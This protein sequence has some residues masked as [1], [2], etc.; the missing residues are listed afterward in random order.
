MKGKRFVGTAASAALVLLLMAGLALAQ[1][2]ASTPL[3]TGFTYQ[4]QLKS[5]DAPYSGTCDFNFALWDALTGGTQIGSTLPKTNVSLSGG[6]FTLALDFGTGRFQ[7]DGRWLAIEVRCPAGSGTYTLLT[8]RQAL[9]AAPYALA[10]PGL[11]TQPNASSP[12]LVGGYNGNWLTSG[13]YAATI[14]GGGFSGSPNRVTDNSGTVGGGYSNQAGDSAGTVADAAKATVGGGDGNTASGAESTVGGGHGN[15]ASGF[16]A[17]VGGGELNGAGGNMSSIGGGYGNAASANLA[18]V[19]GG[20]GNDSGGHAATI[21]GGLGNGANGEYSTVPGGNSNTASGDNSFAA[22][23]RAK[24]TSAGSFVWADSQE[25]D[26]TDYG[27]NTFNVRAENG[28][29][30]WANTT[31]RGAYV[32]NEAAGTTAGQG[33][34]VLGRTDSDYGYGVAGYSYN[35]G[36]GVGAWSYDGDLIRAYDGDFPIGNLRFFVEQ[37]GDVYYY[38]NLVPFVSLPSPD[39]GESEHLS[40]YGLSSTEVWFEELGSGSLVDGR[41]EVAID[42]VFAQTVALTKAYQ[43]YLTATCQEP[44]LL[45]VSEKTAAYFTVQ[46]VGLD[47][48][49]SACGFDYRLAAKRLGYEDLR[50]EVVEIPA[51]VEVDR[52]SEP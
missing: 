12:N 44:V 51:P 36:V 27:V 9:A 52:E 34:A 38:G 43:V 2:P 28:A 5:S 33:T 20:S 45:F 25:E 17:A 19:G 49:P 7:G 37:D 13:V 31:S 23:H 30:I 48:Q 10:L 47:G 24:A 15:T 32:Y 39:G 26:A 35:D 21:G 8:P 22:G 11:W 50:L 46:G 14:A 40:L 1:E 6:Y 18:T 41:A 3:G 16:A 4:G 42:P 29:Y